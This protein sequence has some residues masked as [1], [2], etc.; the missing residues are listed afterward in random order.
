MLFRHLTESPANAP[1]YRSRKIFEVG[2]SVDDRLAHLSDQTMVAASDGV[3][4]ATDIY[5]PRGPGPFPTIVLRT[6]YDRRGTIDSAPEVAAIAAERGYAVV[7]QDVRGKFG[8]GGLPVPLAHESADGIS[9]LEWICQQ[10]WSNGRIGG[11]GESYVGMTQWAA[12]R[13]GHPALLAICPTST[14]A[15]VA[16]SF[17]TSDGVLRL[18]FLATWASYAWVDAEL[19]QRELDWTIR[20]FADVVPKAAGRSLEWLQAWGTTPPGSPAWQL[21]DGNLPTAP[22][23][24]IPTLHRGSWFDIFRVGQMADY[25]IARDAGRVGQHLRMGATDH[26]GQHLDPS[27]TLFDTMTGA[28]ASLSAMA[29]YLAPSL[30][31]LDYYVKGEGSAPQPIAWEL[32]EYGWRFG[33]QWPPPDAVEHVLYLVDPKAAQRSPEGG[34]LGPVPDVLTAGVTWVHDPRDLVPDLMPMEIRALDPYPGDRHINARPDVLVFTSEPVRSDLDLVGPVAC[35][36]VVSSPAN[37]MTLVARIVDLSD[38]G[39][40]RMIAQGAAST[41]THGLATPVTID[42]GDIGY[43]LRPGHRL[44]LT[45]ASSR[46]PSFLPLSSPSADPFTQW[47]PQPMEQRLHAGGSTAPR[48]RMHVQPNT[49][50]EG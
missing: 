37:H 7:A 48:L 50:Q 1:P 4:L 39:D 15:Q 21:L 13:T 49:T 3:P 30:D 17:A 38:V 32:G 27:R 44:Q 8:S 14:T 45:I 18:A 12:A 20:P 35:D 23:V 36:L 29:E 47:N 9:T 41:A 24:A 40:A 42:L 26:V 46:F 34:S 22:T 31:F 25:R 33:E 6:P 10:P 5:L 2:G 19:E 28:P 11:I 43:R 16:G